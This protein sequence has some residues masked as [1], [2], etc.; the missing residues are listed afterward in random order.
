MKTPEN[1]KYTKNDEWIRTEGNVGTVGITD[2]AQTQLKDI[3]FLGFDLDADDEGSAEDSFATVDSV[4]DSVEIYMP[5]SGKILEV[6]EPLS[7]DLEAFKTDPYGAAWM[8]KIEISDP[9]ELDGLMDATAY[10]KYCEER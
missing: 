1:L 5:V 8:V 10:K 9:S 2:Y 4:K 6:N 7:D 3:L